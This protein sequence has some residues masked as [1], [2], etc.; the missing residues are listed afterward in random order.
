M[1]RSPKLFDSSITRVWPVFQ[2]LLQRDPSGLS[3]LPSILALANHNP[4]LARRLAGALTPLLPACLEKRPIRAKTLQQFGKPTPIMEGCFE[5]SLPPSAAFLRWLFRNPQRLHWP[6]QGNQKYSLVPQAKREAL[7]GLHGSQAQAAAQADAL[8]ELARIGAG[9]SHGKWWGFEGI[10]FADCCLET[11]QLV[12]L[13]EG[14]RTESLSTR[15]SWYPE[16]N[17]LMRNLEVTAEIAAGRDFAVLVIAEEPL[18]PLAA[19]TVAR[20]LPHL[21]Q[22]EREGLLSHYLGCVLWKDVCQAVGMDYDQL[23]KT[24]G[25]WL[26]GA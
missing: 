14:K 10:S 22:S 6:R 4:A 8:A 11:A 18:P 16:R 25:D 15:I 1:T 19:Q 20:S 7:V 5:R 13:I 3:W 9:R 21:S 26:G 24:V 17:Q 2:P 23:P 12:L